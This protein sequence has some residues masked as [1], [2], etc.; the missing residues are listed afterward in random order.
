VMT[1]PHLGYRATQKQTP[2][3]LVAALCTLA[4]ASMK[5]DYAIE[6]RLGLP[7]FPPRPES[8]IG[9]DDISRDEWGNVAT[10][11][12]A[13]AIAIATTNPIGQRIPRWLLTITLWIACIAQVAGAVGFTLRATRILPD[14][15]PGPTGWETWLVLAVLDIGAIAWILTSIAVTRYGHPT[16]PRSDR[17]S[18]GGPMRP[19][20]PRK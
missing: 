18:K 16:A 9:R 14:L 5:A 3:A 2:P 12:I 10:A 4:Y 13:A 15:G 20:S 6:G 17:I 19:P 8:T 7:G 11:L 1:R